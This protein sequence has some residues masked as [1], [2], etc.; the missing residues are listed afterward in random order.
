MYNPLPG[1]WP[2]TS[3]KTVRLINGTIRYEG[4]KNNWGDCSPNL[5]I[6]KTL[7]FT[8]VFR[9]FNKIDL[10][11]SLEP[12]YYESVS[13]VDLPFGSLWTAGILPTCLPELSSRGWRWRGSFVR[14]VVERGLCIS[15]RTL[16]RWP[17]AHKTHFIL[18]S[19][20][21]FRLNFISGFNLRVDKAQNRK[22]AI[23][24]SRISTQAKKWSNDLN[25]K[26]NNIYKTLTKSG[27]EAVP[28]CLNSSMPI[29]KKDAIPA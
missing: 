14:W 15:G 8:K 13:W 27:S 7:I 25:W 10:S 11:A 12:P 20:L 21:S 3:V 2:S 4:M 5:I 19:T 6:P 29:Q 22:D 18:S 9:F 17:P 23:K 1:F 26:I 24:R 16:Q 28:A